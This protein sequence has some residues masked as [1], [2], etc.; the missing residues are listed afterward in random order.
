[1]Y[2]CTLAKIKDVLNESREAKAK[3]AQEYVDKHILKQ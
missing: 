3:K 1:L 2:K